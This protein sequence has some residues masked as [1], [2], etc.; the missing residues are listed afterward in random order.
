MAKRGSGKKRRAKRGGGLGSAPPAHEAKARHYAKLAVREA[1]RTVS[2]ASNGDCHAAVEAFED[3][4]R[5]RGMA[6]GHEL[7]LRSGS[8]EMKRTSPKV[9]AT[10]RPMNMARQAMR[11][12]L[13][14]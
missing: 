8:T 7:S 3:A 13:L 1:E 4:A 9:S 5:Y 11:G 6:E 2:I 10:I 12:C 14:K